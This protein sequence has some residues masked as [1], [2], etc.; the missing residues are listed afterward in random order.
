MWNLIIFER[1]ITAFH[2]MLLYLFLG[3][4]CAIIIWVFKTI[5]GIGP[6]CRRRIK[7]IFTCYTTNDD[8]FRWIDWLNTQ[9]DV[10]M[11]QITIT[12]NMFKGIQSAHI[13]M[14]LPRDTRFWGKTSLSTGHRVS[15]HLQERYRSPCGCAV[16]VRCSTGDRTCLRSQPDCWSWSWGRDLYQGGCGS[17]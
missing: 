2:C 13:Y 12:F 11:Y 7:Q 14:W 4:L 16:W 8:C 5:Q 17:R 6:N 15:S 3:C 1:V 10:Y 9:L